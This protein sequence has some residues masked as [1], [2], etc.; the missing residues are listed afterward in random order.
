MTV[1]VGVLLASAP[2]WLDDWHAL[3][4]AQLFAYGIFAMGLSFL[5][6]QAGL[7]CFGQAIFFGIGAYAMTLTTQGRIPGLPDGTLFGLLAAVMLSTVA[8]AVAGLLLFK[9]RGVGGAYFSIV[10][11]ASAVIAERAASHW[12]LLGGFNGLM[13]VPPLR[14]PD[15][16]ELVD[17]LPVYYVLLSAAVAVFALLLTLE[18]SPFGT[19]LRAIR[20]NEQR[21]RFLGIDVFRYKTACLMVSAAVSGLAGALFVT[22]F[23]FVSP[24]LIGLPLSTEVLIWTALGGRE[25]LLAAFAGALLV[26][27]VEGALSDALGNTWILALGLLFVLVVVLFPRGVAGRLWSLPLPKRLRAEVRRGD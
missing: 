12:P 18:R 3:Q 19:G 9:G 15:G 24:A 7:L 25:V 14:W 6:G 22:Q 4:L 26:R 21:S 17:T 23:G 16:R 11:L 27:S 10:T 20:D 2:V 5:W 8:A 1:A 13:N